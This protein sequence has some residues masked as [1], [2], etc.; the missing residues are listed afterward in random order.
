M[1]LPRRSSE[2][3]KTAGLVA[4][5]LTFTGVSMMMLSVLGAEVWH[6]PVWLSSFIRDVGL[7]LAA[8]MAGT[9]LHEKLLR[10]EM[11]HVVVD[12][13]D[14]KLDSGI[15]KLAEVASETAMQTHK[16]F[17]ES[18]PR[19]TGLR[20]VHDTRRN[21]AGYYSWV[22][23]QRPQELFFAGRSVLHRIDAD[24]RTRTGTSAEEILLRRLK[25]GSKITILFLDP[26][27]DILD[28]LAMEEGQTPQA[29]LGD[30]ATSLG[31]SRRLFEL[32][33]RDFSNLPPGAELTIRIYDRVPY[34]AYHKQDDEVIVGFYF[35]S[36]KGSSSAA[37]ELIDGATKE[38][39]GD[40]FVGMLSAAA[41][42]VLV[43]FDG[44]RGRP[45]FNSAL[46]DQLRDSLS[47]V[48]RLGEKKTA[49]AL[50]RHETS[51]KPTG[52]AGS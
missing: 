36:A 8:V 30:V 51:T 32:L 29:L 12:Q 28:R 13:L 42:N 23:E 37:Y 24:I 6:W 20:L 9:I 7:L 22:N 21:F 43:E 45:N 46:F 10:D 31:I 50:D 49:E 47:K 11:V 15:P 40:H 19:M 34:F 27:V 14:E 1:T 33:E 35:L 25:E 39:F 44:A 3:A 2:S 26:R 16:L 52:F 17:S 18:P 38:A 4:Y 41:T 5:G 48:D